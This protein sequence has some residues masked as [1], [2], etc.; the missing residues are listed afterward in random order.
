V[1]KLRGTPEGAAE[2]VGPGPDATA[3]RY[4]DAPAGTA[5]LAASGGGGA[6]PKAPARPKPPSPPVFGFCATEN[7]GKYEPRT[8]LWHAAWTRFK[9]LVVIVGLMAL[10]T[11]THVLLTWRLGVESLVLAPLAQSRQSLP[12]PSP[13]LALLA[14]LPWYVTWSF[15]AVLALVHCV[16]LVWAYLVLDAEAV[17]ASV[18]ERHYFAYTDWRAGLADW[19]AGLANWPARLASKLRGA[20]LAVCTNAVLLTFVAQVAVTTQ[21]L[22][23][24][25]RPALL[26]AAV[27]VV[28]AA[29]MSR[30]PRVLVAIRT[31]LGALR[32]PAG[33]FAMRRLTT[34]IDALSAKPQPSG[35]S[36]GGSGGGGSK[37]WDHGVV[38][39][40]ARVLFE[41]KA[42]AGSGVA[43]ASLPPALA[44]NVPRHFTASPVAA[45]GGFARPTHV[46][47]HSLPRTRM[48]A[49]PGQSCIGP[50]RSI[51]TS[52]EL[53]CGV[54]WCGVVW[55]GVVW[56]GVVWCGVVWCGVV[57]CAVLWCVN[58]CYVAF[59]CAWGC[60]CCRERRRVPAV[61]YGVGQGLRGRQRL[62]RAVANDAAG[63][64]WVRAHGHP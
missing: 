60:V 30:M 61:Q 48:L 36:A 49:A 25:L 14:L 8:S 27:I 43:P 34:A 10:L 35:K 2:L 18:L 38:W 53:W 39:Q 12:V 15:Q 6:A 58:L 7:V 26:C 41:D 16:G 1:A 32:V 28:A 57:C 64:H 21:L 44:T 50:H 51:A 52:P 9:W 42:P 17:R 13:L 55:C 31:A 4:S 62:F 40:R 45:P 20:F 5:P 29:A 46:P 54:V 22:G 24:P 19:W 47:C 56:C 59:L 63:M 23:W 3:F 37:P 33:N 11:G